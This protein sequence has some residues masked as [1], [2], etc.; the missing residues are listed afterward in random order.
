MRS[1]DVAGEGQVMTQA[2]KRAHLRH[3]Q[4]HTDCKDHM[5]VLVLAAHHKGRRVIDGVRGDE[6]PPG[7][8]MM[9]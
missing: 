5:T 4:H 7:A 2:A 6:P 8:R 9:R 3:W 1:C